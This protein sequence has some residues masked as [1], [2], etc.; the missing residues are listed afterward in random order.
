MPHTPRQTTVRSLSE[1]L[2]KL[3]GLR[4]ADRPQSHV[5]WW[6]RG[7][8]DESK[9]LVPGVYRET[10]P[11]ERHDEAKRLAIEQRMHDDFRVLSAGLVH[12]P[13]TPIDLYFLQQHYG[14]PTRLLDW[15]TNPLAGL[16]F[17]VNAGPDTDGSVVMMDVF[18]LAVT[19]GAT[20]SF[21]GVL[22]S[23]SPEV[24]GWLA[25]VLE[26]GTPE[27]F[28]DFVVPIRP[29]LFD[30]RLRLQRGCFTMHVPNR[31]G[32]T[33]RE[34]D[35]LQM[36]VVPKGHK[37]HVYRELKLSGIDEFAIFGDLENLAVSLKVSYGL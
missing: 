26:W 16:Y 22:T 17:A 4:L 5:R 29:E 14:L 11:A 36:F 30:T 20:G 23:S 3:Q 35:S 1:Y 34:N 24:R 18:R 31:P 27:D 6:F 7:Q 28:C 19:Q 8:A 12:P 10:F 32:L 9:E 15:T 33:E 25:P 37:P 21:K 13:P 2:E